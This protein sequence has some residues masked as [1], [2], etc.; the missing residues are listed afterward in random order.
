MIARIGT[1][2]PRAQ[3]A[4]KLTHQPITNGAAQPL[5]LQLSALVFHRSAAED[6][7]P[8]PCERSPT[9]HWE[10]ELTVEGSTL[11][12]CMAAIVKG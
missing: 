5:H 9:R 10:A 11:I 12:V 8:R 4:N 6:A 7:L 3:A 1:V 2:V